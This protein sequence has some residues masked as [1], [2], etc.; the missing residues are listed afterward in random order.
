MRT[1]TTI[2]LEKISGGAQL[3]AR[4]GTGGRAR[5]P[6]VSSNAKNNYCRKCA[7]AATITP[8][9]DTSGRRMNAVI[10]PRCG[11]T[12]LFCSYNATQHIPLVRNEETGRYSQWH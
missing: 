5:L 2:D 4:P 9:Q 10:C 1:L 8:V 3:H 6:G 11:D 7:V 12:W